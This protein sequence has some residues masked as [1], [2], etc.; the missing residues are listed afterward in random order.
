MRDVWPF[1]F[2]LFKFLF[3]S[4]PFSLAA[5][6]TRRAGLPGGKLTVERTQFDPVAETAAAGEGPSPVPGMPTKFKGQ[7]RS[8]LDNDNGGYTA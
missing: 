1:I 5:R 6:D 3:L 7:L 8:I 4:L 2:V